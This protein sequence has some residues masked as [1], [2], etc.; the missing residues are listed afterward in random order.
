LFDL[1][2]QFSLRFI[3]IADRFENGNGTIAS[4]GL[5]KRESKAK[6]KENKRVNK[7]KEG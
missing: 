2:D 1:C 3:V 4:D 7:G 6:D 5:N